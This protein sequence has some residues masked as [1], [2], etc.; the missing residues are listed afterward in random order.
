MSYGH[1]LDICG[2]FFGHPMD[3]RHVRQGYPKDIHGISVCCLGWYY[4]FC[5]KSGFILN[6]ALRLL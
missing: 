6:Q 1:P 5:L 2:T 3:I 4:V